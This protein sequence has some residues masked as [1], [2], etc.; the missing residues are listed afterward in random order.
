VR[1]GDVTPSGRVRLDAVARYL[2]DI[3]DDDV[4]DAGL[5]GTWVLRWVVLELGTLPRFRE[6]IEVVTF[7]SGSG[8]RWAERRTTVRVLGAAGAPAVEAV[9]LWVHVDAHG[10]PATLDPVFPASYGAGAQR[11]VG[12]SRLHHPAPPGADAPAAPDRRTWP[13]RTTDFDLMGHVNNAAS[14]SAVEEALA[15]H[16]EGRRITRAE[17]E[18][19]APVA[20]T[21][22]L[23]L[24]AVS[25]A[26]SL[27]CWLVVPVDPDPAELTVGDRV[28]TSAVLQ[29]GPPDP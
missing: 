14:W 23:A 11:R 17:V 9:A 21:D 1:L 16:G 10:R 7:C 27:R 3:A 13:V 4:D 2:Q 24:V 20:S 28:A 29:L 15:R 12:A 5:P 6:D 19:R 8:P 22:E 25:D 26:T 18:Y